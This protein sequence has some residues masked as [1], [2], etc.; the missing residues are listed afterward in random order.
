MA[1]CHQTYV[2]LHRTDIH[3]NQ[4]CEACHGPASEHL[5]SRGTKPGTIISFK[6]TAPADQNE[7]CLQCHE[8]HVKDQ[9]VEKN[10]RT[11]THDHASIACAACH[12]NHYTVPKGTPAT[13]VGAAPAPLP[14]QAKE[15]PA[16]VK[17]IRSTYATLGVPDGR[18]ATIA[19][20]TTKVLP[21]RPRKLATC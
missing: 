5:I 2:K 20:G 10:W 6:T 4:G 12:K 16:E 17:A 19:I 15:T 11:S 21:K 13:Q 7:I 14:P 1:T 9:F 3:R 18:Y 8:Q